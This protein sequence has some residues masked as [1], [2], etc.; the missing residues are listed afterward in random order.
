[1]KL[2]RDRCVNGRDNIGQTKYKWR[3]NI[4]DKQLN[5]RLLVESFSSSLW[6]SKQVNRKEKGQDIKKAAL[7]PTAKEKK[8]SKSNG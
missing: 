1:M 3:R 4:D 5:A 6:T 2:L 8:L 7:G